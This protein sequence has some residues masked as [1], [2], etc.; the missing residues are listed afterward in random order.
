[1]TLCT[2]GGL[3]DD[4]GVGNSVFAGEEGDAVQRSLCDVW[5]GVQGL[6]KL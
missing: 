6:L 5:V 4:L 3:D 1:M 2:A